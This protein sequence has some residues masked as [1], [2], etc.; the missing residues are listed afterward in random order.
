M[1][2]RKS[3]KVK[4]SRT[5]VL[6]QRRGKLDKEFLCYVCQHE[7]S[8]SVKI[9]SQAKMAYL[10]CRICHRQ[11]TMHTTALDQP[12]DVYTAWIDSCREAE[13]LQKSARKPGEY[14]YRPERAPQPTQEARSAA[15]SA[16]KVMPRTEENS[17]PSDDK[18]A[19][20]D[21][22]PPAARQTA[23]KRKIMEEDLS[24]KS[25]SA[26]TGSK[27]SKRII[28]AL[29]E[30]P[31]EPEFIVDTLKGDNLFDDD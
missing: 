1:G 4:L 7:K 21:E 6:K 17:K 28:D 19:A 24:S 13:K 18:V 15:V 26:I 12:V 22:S 30:L 25:F 2:K 11:F 14:A 16:E 8:V 23:V 27:R 10:A 20:A 3:Q 31:D 9:N 5:Q 29:D